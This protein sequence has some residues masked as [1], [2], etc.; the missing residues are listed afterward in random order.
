MTIWNPWHGCHKISPGCLNCYMFRRDAE[1]GK[2]STQ[3][4]RTRDFGLAVARK[5]DG[6]YK[7]REET[8]YLCMTSDFFV[9]EADSW[10]P[11]IWAMVRER[12]DLSFFIITKRI[13]RFHVA[14][15]PD[16][17]D[18]YPNVTLFVTCENQK[19]ADARLPI[20][21]DLPLRHRAV[22]HEPMLEP[23]NIAPYLAGGRIETVIVGGESGPAARLLD[24]AWVLNTRDQCARFG[25]HF[26]FK[27][28]GRNF[29]KDGKYYVIPRRLQIPQARRAGINLPGR[30]A[31]SPVS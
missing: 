20:L 9:E 3:V 11:E 2:D 27:Q 17:G 21:L 23:V 29:R 15:P 22:I 8:V 25:V 28:T 30:P 12:A 26:L 4:V 6:T 24:Y 13:H 7:V 1:F 16:W 19:M 18:G 31:G 5:R 14:L 10:R